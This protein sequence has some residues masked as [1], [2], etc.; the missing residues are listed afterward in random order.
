MLVNLG[1]V[2]DIVRQEEA[3]LFNLSRLVNTETVGLAAYVTLDSIHGRR[4]C[5]ASV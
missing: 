3:T 4:Q 5:N 1:L 2:T